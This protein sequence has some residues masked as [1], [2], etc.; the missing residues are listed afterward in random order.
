M[1]PESIWFSRLGRA[2]RDMPASRAAAGVHLWHLLICIDA[3]YEAPADCAG[4][5]TPGDADQ[6]R[7]RLRAL[8]ALGELHGIGPYPAP[9]CCEGAASVS[10]LGSDHGRTLSRTTANV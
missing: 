4:G 10:P 2:Q 3:N 5:Y 9:D 1:T 7:E 6:E 8:N